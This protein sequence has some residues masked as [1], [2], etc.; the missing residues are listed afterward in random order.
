V[1]STAYS[2]VTMDATS[3]TGNATTFSA[4][5]GMASPGWV[6]LTHPDAGTLRV[7]LGAAGQ[8]SICSTSG[9]L[10]HHLAC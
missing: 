6:N 3:F 4:R 7:S 5:L 9:G 8:V 10:G 1:D 2:G